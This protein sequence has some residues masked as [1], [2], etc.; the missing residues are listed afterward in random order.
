MLWTVF[1]CNT[2][3]EFYSIWSG[4]ATFMGKKIL[5]SDPRELWATSGWSGK[6]FALLFKT[7]GLLP[8][9]TY[10]SVTR[11]TAPLSDKGR[12]IFNP[13]LSLRFETH[14]EVITAGQKSRKVRRG[15]FQFFF[16]CRTFD[17]GNLILCIGHRIIGEKFSEC[18][19]GAKRRQDVAVQRKSIYFKPQRFSETLP[20]SFYTWKNLAAIAQSNQI[21]HMLKYC[22]SQ[23]TRS[24]IQP[25]SKITRGYPVQCANTRTSA[26]AVRPAQ[27]LT[28]S[29]RH[30]LVSNVSSPT[31]QTDRS[32]AK[33]L[34][35]L[36]P[37]AV[38]S[39]TDGQEML[40]A[41][42]WFDGMLRFWIRLLH[43]LP[44]SSDWR[45]TV[46]FNLTPM[47]GDRQINKATRRSGAIDTFIL[48]DSA[49]RELVCL[50]LFVH[51]SNLCTFA[52]FWVLQAFTRAEYLYNLLGVISRSAKHHNI[53][54][55]RKQSMLP[56]IV[57]TCS[58]TTISILY[59]TRMRLDACLCPWIGGFC[60]NRTLA[61]NDCFLKQRATRI[62]LIN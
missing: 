11:A 4:K 7:V 30:R 28:T 35:D 12:Q 52:N 10:R 53:D 3:R 24:R 47:L 44:L 31:G 36:H 1:V 43:V 29:Q 20:T 50:S 58:F 62:A 27:I 18:L 48:I 16:L 21:K 19:C 8:N 40:T 59:K 34:F 32:R 45:D 9:F 41:R 25:Y 56:L 39:L 54:C 2:P 5:C 26:I 61:D 23:S 60:L 37:H 46:F 15:F 38:T 13:A 42:N 14:G 22:V 33:L 55:N 57:R 6:S 51:W 49:K 17:I